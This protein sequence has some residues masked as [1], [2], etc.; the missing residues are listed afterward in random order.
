MFGTTRRVRITVD[1][2]FR[3][4]YKAGYHCIG[5]FTCCKL[6]CK[7][8]VH[9]DVGKKFANWYNGLAIIRIAVCQYDLNTAWISDLVW[10]S[11]QPVK[12]YCLT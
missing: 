6:F 3:G 1:V 4:V 7:M 8:T 12:S 11:E 5:K 2:H 10:R 9:R